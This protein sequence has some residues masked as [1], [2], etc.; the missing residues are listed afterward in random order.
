MPV[1]TSR[2]TCKTCGRWVMVVV[3]I[4]QSQLNVDNSSFVFLES[5]R[6][7]PA[8]TTPIGMPLPRTRTSS[9]PRPCSISPPRPIYRRNLLASDLHFC[10]NDRYIAPQSATQTIDTGSSRAPAA[11]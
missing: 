9:G 7:A 8:A 11:R 6:F 2:G 5:C 10:C 1:A 4:A 3:L